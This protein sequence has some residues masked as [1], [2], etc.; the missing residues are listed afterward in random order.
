MGMTLASS[1]RFFYFLFFCEE[2]SE[3]RT[4]QYGDGI[5][6]EHQE[7]R[8]VI[9]GWDLQ[10]F[11]PGRRLEQAAHFKRNTSRV[12][13]QKRQCTMDEEKKITTEVKIKMILLNG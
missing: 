1:I 7:F 5:G 12:H 11:P 13:E 4:A 10:C 2:A 3:F 6:I 9:Y 8:T